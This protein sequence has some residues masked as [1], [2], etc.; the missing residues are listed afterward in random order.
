MRGGETVGWRDERSRE[1]M[2]WGRGGGVG[3]GDESL[4]MTHHVSTGL[5]DGALNRQHNETL[6]G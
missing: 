5:L 3:G 2:M 4:Q 1:V 6:C